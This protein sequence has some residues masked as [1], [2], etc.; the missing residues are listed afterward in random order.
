[1][2]IVRSSLDCSLTCICRY[3]WLRS[4]LLNFCP[5]VSL[6]KRSLMLGKGYCSADNTGFTVT[7]K[8]PQIL[9]PPSFFRTGTIGVAHL[10]SLTVSNTLFSKSSFKLA[11]TLG[12]SANGRGW[13]FKNFGWHYDSTVNFTLI[14]SMLPSSCLKTSPCFRRTPSKFS[15][16]GVIMCMSSCQSTLNCSS[17]ERPICEG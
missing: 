8:S 13:A 15:V 3:T 12:L 7:L 14:P 16:F 11:S 17:Q 9:M 2:L 1:M 10:L 5:P 4:I 6:A